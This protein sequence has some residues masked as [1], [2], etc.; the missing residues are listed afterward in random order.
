MS[1][2]KYGLY[3][4]DFIRF[5]TDAKFDVHLLKRLAKRCF[6]VNKLGFSEM[7]EVNDVARVQLLTTIQ[8]I[9]KA[10]DGSLT[11]LNLIEFTKNFDEGIDMLNDIHENAKLVHV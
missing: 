11:E 3:N 9:F 2:R 7:T 5:T 8:D 10:N 6:E 4:I 1:S